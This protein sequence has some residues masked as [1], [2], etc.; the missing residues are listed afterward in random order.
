M[1]PDMRHAVNGAVCPTSYVPLSGVPTRMTSLRTC[2][3]HAMS[4]SR[5]V[6]W[7]PTQRI[8]SR[9][10]RTAGDVTQKLLRASSAQ[11]SAS[12]SL[13]EAGRPS[14][15]SPVLFA[16]KTNH[17]RHHELDTTGPVPLYTDS[18]AWPPCLAIQTSFNASVVPS[19]VRP[20]Q[21][22]VN[23][24]L[25]RF[26]AAPFC[27]PGIAPN[28]GTRSMTCVEIKHEPWIT[29]SLRIHRFGGYRGG[30]A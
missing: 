7:C 9:S 13:P 28:F 16:K 14:P 21:I 15:Q 25:S 4:S 18:C 3:K 1:E 17:A 29:I 24:P 23:P 6:C 19:L 12:R 26:A 27:S 20:P 22:T 8:D 11:R 5:A 2:S 30:Q 10:N